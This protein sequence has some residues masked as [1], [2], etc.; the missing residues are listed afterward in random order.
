[1]R[2]KLFRDVVTMFRYYQ[3]NMYVVLHAVESVC[4]KLMDTV[5]Y[6]TKIAIE[7]F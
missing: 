1:M 3:G 2:R 7:I 6:V 5:S 4:L